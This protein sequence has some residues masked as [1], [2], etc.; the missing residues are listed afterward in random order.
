[1]FARYYRPARTSLGPF[2]ARNPGSATSGDDDWFSNFQLDH[3]TLAQKT[4]VLEML[5]G[6]KDAFS[7]GDEDIGKIS[8]LHMKINLSDQVPVQKT[9]MSIPRPLLREVKDYIQDLL[10]REWI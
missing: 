5:R 7:A 2:T 6:E 1:M 4:T 8:D 9:Y 10:R 3:L